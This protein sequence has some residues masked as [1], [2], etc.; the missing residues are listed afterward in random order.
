MALGAEVL[1]V[2]FAGTTFTFLHRPHMQI[3]RCVWGVVYVLHVVD[4]WSV[5]SKFTVSPCSFSVLLRDAGSGGGC[6]LS[7]CCS[8]RRAQ[9]L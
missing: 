5:M 9:E 8:A 1:E 7:T 2:L 6:Q 4:F 3:W